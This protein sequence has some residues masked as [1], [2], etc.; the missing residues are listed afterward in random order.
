MANVFISPNLSDAHCIQKAQAHQR[1]WQSVLTQK[2][3]TGDFTIG[4]GEDGS[5]SDVHKEPKEPFNARF[6]IWSDP[7]RCPVFLSEG[8]NTIAYAGAGRDAAGAYLDTGH[9]KCRSG[10]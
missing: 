5:C 6:Y 7:H 10:H 3:S 2:G 4:H 9:C 8:G 1:R